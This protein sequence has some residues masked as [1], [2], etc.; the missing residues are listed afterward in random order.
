MTTD[1]ALTL[2]RRGANGDEIL[3]ILDT[4]ASDDTSDAAQPTDQEVQF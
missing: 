2:L 3:E 1:L 4:I